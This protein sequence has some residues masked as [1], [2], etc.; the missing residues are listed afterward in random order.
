MKKV[1][2]YIAA[3]IAIWAVLKMVSIDSFMSFNTKQKDD[4]GWIDDY[5]LATSNNTPEDI[6]GFSL[7]G[8]VSDVH[9]FGTMEFFNDLK[10]KYN[11][12][13][14]SIPEDDF[15]N[16]INQIN[17]IYEPDLLQILPDALK[18][19]VDDFK[20]HWNMSNNINEDTFLCEDQSEETYRVFK[21]EN[22]K[23]YIKKIT[24]YNVSQD[25]D[26]VLIYKK[27]LKE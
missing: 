27:M 2:I 18:C 7:P 11:W 23:M 26:G 10:Y 8:S 15:D 5:D 4:N 9:T 12:L 14:A 6:I 21:F 17:A 1:I 13:T 25:N 20:K 3:I 19:N 16:L 22:G 24:K